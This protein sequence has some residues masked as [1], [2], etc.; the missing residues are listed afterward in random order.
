M[1]PMAV[2]ALVLALSVPSFARQ[3]TPVTKQQVTPPPA[4]APAQ[5][6]PPRGRAREGRAGADVPPGLRPDEVQQI[7]DGWE[8]ATAEKMLE[9]TDQQYVPFIQQ[10][11]KLQSGRRQQFMQRQRML[12]GLRQA[13]NQQQPTL[14]DAALDTRVKQFDDLERKQQQELHNLHAAIDAVL[15]PRQRARFRVLQEQM[16]RRKLEVLS[17][18]MRA[19]G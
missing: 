9:L 11:R 8:I 4:A 16:E 6:L 18:A 19:G 1:R 12:Q 10:L 3:R 13:I 5:E 2:V 17:R 14:D 15:T 7:V